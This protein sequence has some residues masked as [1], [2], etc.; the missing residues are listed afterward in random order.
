MSSEWRQLGGGSQKLAALEKEPRD[1]DPRSN[2]L[3]F[4]V[5]GTLG[6]AER[7]S[8]VLGSTASVQQPALLQHNH[9]QKY[10]E[11]SALEQVLKDA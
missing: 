3:L 10:E 4:A 9:L 8:E 11:Q 2:Q 1:L 6:A 7:P 5:S